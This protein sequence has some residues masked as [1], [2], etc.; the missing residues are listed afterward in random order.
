VAKSKGRDE[1]PKADEARPTVVTAKRACVVDARCMEDLQWWVA[2]QPKVATKVLDLMEHVLREP[3]SGIGKPEPL[4]QLG[5]NTWSRRITG[6][7][8]LVY[9]V[10][11]DRVTFL[12]AR[13]HY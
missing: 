5:P 2:T 12:Q 1:R 11:N 13:M 3:F 8:R 7:H 10:A 4:K 6:E 9:V